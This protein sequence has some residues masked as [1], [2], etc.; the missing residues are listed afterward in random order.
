M[1]MCGK[2]T[3]NGQP[4]YSWDGNGTGTHPAIGPTP[5]EDDVVLY[6]EP[7]RCGGLD[8][9]SHHFT[10]VKNHGRRFILFRHGGGQG[11]IDVGSGHGLECMENM[12]TNARYWL[13]WTI[14]RAQNS[15]ATAAREAER[16]RWSSAALQKRIKTSRR[17][18]KWKVWIE[19]EAVAA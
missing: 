9:H 15:A 7:G 13:M 1:C 6:D 12:D 2:P 8:C 18:R 10:M 11:R 14:Y 16:T 19:Q 5:Q 4:G 3:I 17:G